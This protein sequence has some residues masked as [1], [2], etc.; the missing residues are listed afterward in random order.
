MPI[1]QICDHK[2]CTAC[3]ACMSVCPKGAISKVV[4]TLGEE[5]PFVDPKKCVDCGLC[6]SLCPTNN[7]PN[8]QRAGYCYAA[9]SKS[10][11]DLLKSSSGG[12]GTVLSR[13]LVNKGGVVYGS[14]FSEAQVFHVRID[15]ETDTDK[16]RGSK[17]VK[18]DIRDCYRRVLDDLRNGK[19]V[20]FIGTPCQV[21]GLKAFTDKKYPDLITVDLVC[22]GTPPFLYLKEHLDKMCSQSNKGK[23]WD[24]AV[25]RFG[26]SFLMKVFYKGEI[27]YQKGA[28]DD[29]YYSAFLDGMIFRSNCYHCQYACPERVGDLTI[30]D[31]WGI[32][33]RKIGSD[34][35][36]KISLILPNT[37]KGTALLQTCMDELNL[38]KLPIE[39]ALNPQQGNLLH[40]SVPH[41]ERE[42]F[43]QLYPKH[44]FVGSIKR[45][46]L[47]KAI[48]KRDRKKK[49]KGSVVYRA[50]RHVYHKI[51]R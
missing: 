39:D 20:L 41:K 44:G 43:E 45:T 35:D 21:A 5:M 24:T 22:H 51:K 42:L 32:N 27:V 11:D 29:F 16:L 26:K 28:A 37:Q 15:S 8:M 3:F 23:R 18:S 49:V 36:G 9:W 19:K 33:R 50:V 47:G 25:F 1:Q 4:N 13:G 48:I 17:Y 2:L 14:T 34:Y 38:F 46:E 40:P 6:I 7:K 31:F 10:E 12:I 30:G